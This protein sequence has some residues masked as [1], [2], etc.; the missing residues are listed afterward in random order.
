MVVLIPTKE[1]AYCRYLKDAGERLP[2]TFTR[3]CYVE[4]QAKE[5]VVQFLAT[6]KIA[7]VDVTGPLE[8]SIRNH[9]QIY[10]TGSDGHPQATGHSLIARAVYDAVRR[11]GLND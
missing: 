2:S 7:Y 1:R 6:R 8:A 4:E 11:Q 3:L 10:P 5:D 9:L